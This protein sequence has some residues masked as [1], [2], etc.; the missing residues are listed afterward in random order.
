MKILFI[1]NSYTYF[2][3]L[4]KVFEALA[5]ENGRD[6]TAYSVTKGG[7]HLYEN[8]LPNETTQRLDALLSEHSFDILVLQEQSFFAL[9]DEEKFCSAAG[10]LSRKVSAPRTVM[11][12][13]WGRKTGATLLAE[14]GW[15]SEGMT[16]MLHEAYSRCA[17]KIGAD[18]S[19]VGLC[20]REITFSHDDT[21]LYTKDK[22]HPSAL[23]TALAAIVHYATVFGELPSSINA[24]G[25]DEGC[26]RIFVDAAKKHCAL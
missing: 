5:N 24:L 23:G 20:F 10:E 13:T 2:N 22:S 6:V 19:P 17:D 21:E 4:P 12:C 25:L 14:R 15:C 26:A 16:D 18:I 8:L 3:D 7:R 9:V 11:Y 1:G